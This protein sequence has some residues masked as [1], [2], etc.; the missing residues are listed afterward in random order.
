MSLLEGPPDAKRVGKYILG[1]I[2]G[3]GATGSYVTN[4]LY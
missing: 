2:L 1:E 4:V 3:A